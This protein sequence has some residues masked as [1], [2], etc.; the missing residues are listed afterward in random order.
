MPHGEPHW[1]EW[2]FVSAMH[3]E[4]VQLFGGPHGIRDRGLVESALDRPR[5]KW[6]YG[7]RDLF[8]LAAAAGFGITRNH[9][10]IDGNK[11]TAL[12]SMYVFLELNGFELVAP[13]AGAVET[14]LQVAAG[15]L[16]E[17]E[18]AAWLRE[19]SLPLPR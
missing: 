19:H 14:I 3:F 9:G 15:A 6:G 10:F 11:R 4:Q 1:L 5:N 2:R 13:E 7:E 16:T 12:L 18:L 17:M 8:L